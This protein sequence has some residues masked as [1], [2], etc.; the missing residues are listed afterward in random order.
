MKKIIIA[1]AV[2]FTTS[3]YAVPSTHETVVKNFKA[4]FPQ[5]QNIKWYT[6]TDYYEVSF[7]D[8]NIAERVYYNEDG[9]IFRTIKYYDESKLNPFI[10]QRIKEKFRNKSINT[11]T[12]IQED[13]D[14][15]YQVI[16]QDNKHLYVVNCN[17]DGEMHLE[18]KYIKG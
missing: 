6:A 14:L 15:L 17:G 10:L 3:A 7:T 9:Q 13:S 16:L 4:T 12:E 1:L 2:L 11:I 8:K 18:H 5:A